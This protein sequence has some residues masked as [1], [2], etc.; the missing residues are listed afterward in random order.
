MDVYVLT[1][2]PPYESR[3]YVLGV[4]GTEE[5]VRDAIHEFQDHGYYD[6]DYDMF[7]IQS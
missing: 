3:S 4:Y 6:L 5:A 7:S 1:G 2:H